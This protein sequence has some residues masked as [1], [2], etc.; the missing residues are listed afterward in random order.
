MPCSIAL[1]AAVVMPSGAQEARIAGRVGEPA[2]A[3]I[4]RLLDSARAQGLPTDPLVAK[5]LEG[6]AKRAGD[7]RILLAVRSLLGNLAAARA[8]LGA[9]ATSPE[10]SAGA[11]ALRAGADAHALTRLRGTR[12]DLT[13]P[14]G[15]LADLVVSGVPVDT[16][17]QAIRELA[18]RR[19]AD[20]DFTTLARQ[21]RQD[22]SAGV[23]PGFAASARAGPPAHLPAAPPSAAPRRPAGPPSERP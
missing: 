8:A 5:A 2:R 22:V 21:V 23:P 7:D 17:V 19:A 1:L 13:V 18:A 11:T 12:D 16:A 3:A 20:G 10:I 14:L 6:V 15:A 4:D 9:D